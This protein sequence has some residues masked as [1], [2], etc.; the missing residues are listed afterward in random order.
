[1]GRASF[2]LTPAYGRDYNSKKAVLADY[3]AGK[4]FISQPDGRY[5]NIDDIA[6][7]LA[8]HVTIRYAKLRKVLVV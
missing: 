6:K 4:D 7:A 2:T 3:N 8:L 1:M 5:C